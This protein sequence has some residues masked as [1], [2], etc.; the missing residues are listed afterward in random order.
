MKTYAPKYYQSFKCI[1]DKCRRNCCIGW[2]IGIDEDTADYYSTV[3][4]DIGE[5]LSRSVVCD[6]GEH[7][8]RMCEGGR[9]PFLLPSGLCELI[10]ELGEESLSDI[11]RE[12][13]R[14]YN[15]VADREEV[16]VGLCCEAAA[17][18]IL[19]GEDSSRPELL[20]EDSE[21]ASLICDF[22]PTEDRD[23]LISLFERAGHIGELLTEIARARVLEIPNAAERVSILMA[24]PA[25]DRESYHELLS[26]VDTARV[27]GFTAL[28]E[29]YKRL[30]SYLAY[31]HASAAESE[32]DLK[33]AIGFIAFF[34][35]TF[36][37][38]CESERLTPENRDRIIHIATVLSSEIEYSPDNTEVIKSLFAS[39]KRR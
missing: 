1:A 32:E 31:R 5:K 39:N 23:R 22:D 9:C 29:Q 27:G 35:M 10:C 24:M 33:Q 15:Y 38:V 2:D 17:D 25:M 21:D 28:D 3:G 18:L 16:G 19:F 26:R 30:C 6:D 4:G 37:D 36:I 20:S 12:H 8:F 14:F 7:S 34:A 13:P 11:C